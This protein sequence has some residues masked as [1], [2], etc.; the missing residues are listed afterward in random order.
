METMKDTPHKNGGKPLARFFGQASLWALTGFAL[1]SALVIS[2]ETS[3]LKGP[4]LFLIA[5]VL[6]APVSARL[7]ERVRP[8]NRTWLRIAAGC[9]L[10]WIGAAWGTA[11]MVGL[12]WAT[13]PPAMV[14]KPELKLKG[15]VSGVQPEVRIDGE[16]VSVAQDGGFEK[17]V[18]LRKG[19]N[20]ITVA[21]TAKSGSGTRK[22]GE[23]KLTVRYL[24][25]AEYEQE[26][27]AEARKKKQ[28][29][30][31]AMALKRRTEKDAEDCRDRLAAKGHIM[32]T[33]ELAEK[34]CSKEAAAHFRKSGPE[35][36]AD[37]IQKKAEKLPERT[38]S[39]SASIDRKKEE[40]LKAYIDTVNSLGLGRFVAAI[41]NDSELHKCSVSI[42]V[43]D[44][45]HYEPKQVRLQAAQ[46]MWKLYANKCYIEHDRD[47][48]RI[49]LVDGNGNKVGGSSWLGGSSIKVND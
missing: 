31:Q 15:S 47:M 4:W 41:T 9:V 34:H 3:F 29:E 39:E 22:A 21:Y 2:T 17:T 28:E 5:A 7:L 26:Q 16:P 18:K 20:I 42:V 33:P 25:K 48:V 36:I 23:K 1:L 49:K 32:A 6:F 12:E 45:W 30:E 27:L 46:N 44:V 35:S 37:R 10:F 38:E 24:T 19:A 14:Q 43:R 11:Q 8:L 13:K 40:I